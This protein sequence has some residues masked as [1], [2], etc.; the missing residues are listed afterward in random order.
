M[1]QK[2][3][4][5]L[6]FWVTTVTLLVPLNSFSQE[7]KMPSSV[8]DLEAKTIEGELIKLSEYKGKVALIVNVASKCGFTSQYEGLEELYRKYSDKGFVVLGFP[9]NDFMGQEPGSDSDIKTF[10]K[11]TYD[12]T[13]PMFSKGPVTGKD[14]QPIFKY[15]TEGG[16]KELQSSVKW[17]FEKFLVNKDGVIVDRWRSFTGPSSSDISKKIEELLG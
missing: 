14:K 9:S 6:K 4:I 5:F 17:N 3:N 15:L 2:R 13:F 8:Y 10:C 12:V 11:T 16:P 7:N 1:P